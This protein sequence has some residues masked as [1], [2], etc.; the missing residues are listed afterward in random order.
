MI[1]NRIYEHVFDKQWVITHMPDA[2]LQRQR[3]AATRARWQVGSIAAVVLLGMGILSAWALGNAQRADSERN[4]AL[5]SA[6]AESQAKTEANAQRTKAQQQATF[7]LAAKNQA[8]AATA[9]AQVA[10]KGESAAKAVGQQIG[11]PPFG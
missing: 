3:A 2:E 11:S 6:A 1:R 7:A 4:K 8:Q 5:V 9:K 10:L